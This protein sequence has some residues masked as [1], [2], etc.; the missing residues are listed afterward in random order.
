[1][2]RTFWPN[3][4][5][6]GRRISDQGQTGPYRVVVGVAK[7]SKYLTL[8]EAARPYY[9]LPLQQDFFPSARL[10]VRTEGDPKNLVASIRNLIRGVDATVPISNV[11]TGSDHLDLALLVPRIGAMLLG[12]AGLVVLVLAVI[13]LYG[14]MSY[15]V[16]RRTQE[17]GIR[18]ALGAQRPDVLLMVI[19][20]GMSLVG[21]GLLLGFVVAFAITRILTS[22]LYSISATDPVTFIAVSLLLS[23]VA[24]FAI[25]MPARRALKID[26]IIA[27]RYD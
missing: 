4:N 13:G 23:A 26:P 9:Y 14:I 27:L 20:E 19:K 1:M 10:H 11:Q 16:V 21:I 3:E 8:G 24:L 6:I 12:P 7:E 15:S 2:A 5:P 25:F 22:L 18:I 17:I